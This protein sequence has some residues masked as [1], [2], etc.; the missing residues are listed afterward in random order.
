MRN[1]ISA[2]LFFLLGANL[3]VIAEEN[4]TIRGNA[5]YY[6]DKFQGRLMSNGEPYHRDSMTCA[7]MKYPFGTLLN[8]K[9]PING[10][11]VVVRVTDR[12]PFTKRFLI[13]LSKAAAKQLGLI[14]KGF[15]LVEITPFTPQ[16]VPYKLKE[17][18]PE[19]PELNIEFFPIAIYPDPAWQDSSVVAKPLDYDAS[20]EADK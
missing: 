16:S 2:L 7:H 1:R 12:G 3:Y 17:D 11:E 9:N 13:D 10:K 19:I 18:V 6:S 8:V 15:A 14:N 4:D 20:A 5:S